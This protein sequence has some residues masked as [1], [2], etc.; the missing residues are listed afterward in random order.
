MELKKGKVY[1]KQKGQAAVG[2]VVAA[3]VVLILIAIGYFVTVTVQNSV[4]QSTFT[5]GQNT[6][7]DAILS[8]TN[9]SFQLLTIVG[10]ALAAAI[11]IGVILAFTRFR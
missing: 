5:A 11:I 6:T 7:Y 4:D 3:I 2:G 10:I 1:T 9:Q 8:T